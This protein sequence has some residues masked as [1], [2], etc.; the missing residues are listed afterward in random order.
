MTEPVNE[1]TLDNDRVVAPKTVAEMDALPA[2]K[3]TE[4]SISFAN[5]MNKHLANAEGYEPITPEQAWCLIYTHRV[6]QGSDEREAE[7]VALKNM[8]SEDK[9]RRAAE[10]EAKKEA[11]EAARLE[12]ERKKKERA[13]EAEAAKKAKEAQAADNDSDLEGAE[14]EPSE[15]P[16]RRRPPAKPVQAGVSAAAI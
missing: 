16:K 1:N 13:A 5:F 2:V 15:A 7:K 4:A 8:K 9:E 3:A 14:G 12:K 6:W 10:R 11:A